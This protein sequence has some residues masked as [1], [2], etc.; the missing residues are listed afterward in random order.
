ML[1]KLAHLPFPILIGFLNQRKSVTFQAYFVT[2]SHGILSN[3]D[4]LLN[5]RQCADPASIVI[6]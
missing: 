6:I 5:G 4:K 3:C 2:I 1:G